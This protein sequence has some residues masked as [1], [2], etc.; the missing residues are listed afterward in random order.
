MTSTK[1]VKTC[2]FNE[3]FVKILVKNMQYVRYK[4]ITSAEKLLQKSHLNEKRSYR[5][6][7]YCKKII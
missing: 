1:R 4:F 3:I 2:E 6:T 5:N 7:L